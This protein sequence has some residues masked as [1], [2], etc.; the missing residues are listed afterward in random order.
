MDW[1]EFDT[2]NFAGCWLGTKGEFTA[3]LH[4]TK[5]SS[6]AI[7]C[8]WSVG[9]SPCENYVMDATSFAEAREEI[10]TWI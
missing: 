1:I 10:D 7:L 5:D 3:I 9:V 6:R 4:R 2:P 8:A